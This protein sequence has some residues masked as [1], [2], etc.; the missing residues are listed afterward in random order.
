M[1]GAYICDLAAVNQK[2][3]SDYIYSAGH[4]LG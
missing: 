3:I 4:R 1:S 2:V